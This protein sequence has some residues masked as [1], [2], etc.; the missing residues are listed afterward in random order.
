[1]KWNFVKL[2]PIFISFCFF[3]I[4]SNPYPG[5]TFH[6][7]W[8][9]LQSIM[10]IIS[11][12]KKGVYLR[13]GDGDINLAN[14]QADLLQKSNRQLSHEMQE[15]LSLNG[16]TILKCL[17]VNGKFA[18]FEDGMLPGK[19]AAGIDFCQNIFKRAK[20]YWGAPFK[21]IYS[22]VALSFLSTDHPVYSLR[23][24]KF[25]R[26]CDNKILVGN[27]NTPTE[28]RSLLLNNHIFIPTPSEQSYSKIDQIEHECILAA[29]NLP[30]YKIICLAMG[31]SGR[32]LA[33]RLWKQLDNI[34]IFDYG[35]T[36]DALCGWDTRAWISLSS[37]NH[38]EFVHKL[39][40]NV[41]IVYSAALL[42]KDQISRKKEY[43]HSLSILKKIGY[44]PF[45]VESCSSNSFSFLNEWSNH[46]FYSSS[47]NP[48][49]KNKGVNEGKSLL[50][51]LNNFNFKD[52]DLIIKLTG[53]YFFEKD[54]FIQ[55]VENNP[56]VDA[57]VKMDEHGQVFTGC[58]AMRNLYLKKFYQGL[59][60][61]KM[62]KE[63]I[64]IEK[65]MA[66]YI[67]KIEKEGA[68]IKR[69]NNLHL[70]AN[71]YGAGSPKITYW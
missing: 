66:N 62:E 27:C 5:I 51:G 24:L 32:A 64:N 17:P 30:G 61:L 52:N 11:K 18:L 67:S 46:V 23:F 48:T 20:P 35:S 69:V 58:F 29:K 25:L 39:S 14:N 15:A 10:D 34:F 3:C 54:T 21:N 13:F 1:M 8:D 12:Q 45:I 63:M 40:H 19:H 28:L 57:F 37:F 50:L 2:A 60:F 6:K 71:I 16:P 47:N 43:I 4:F 55:L 26:S 22:M 53:R 9:T 33:K 41:H 65:L 42:E 49:I 38:E 44:I 7:S 31:C 56:H 59:D 68:K 70:T 36:F